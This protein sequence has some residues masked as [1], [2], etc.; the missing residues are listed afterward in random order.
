MTIKISVVVPIFNVE[1]YLNRC[2]ESILAQLYLNLE[3][4]LIDDGSTD[5]SLLICREYEKKDAR[6]KVYTQQNKGVS[7]ARNLGI[8]HATGEFI[9]F[10]DPD[11]WIEPRMYESMLNRIKMD[12]SDICLCDYAV[13]KNNKKIERTLNLEELKITGQENIFKSIILPLIG[14]NEN[15]INRIDGFVW[16]LLIKRNI[17]QASQVVF[18]KDIKIMEDLLFC[19]SLFQHCNVVSYD[20]NIFYNYLFNPKS[21][22][23]RYKPNYYEINKKVYYKMRQLVINNCNGDIECSLQNRYIEMMIGCIVNEIIYC[24]KS[25]FKSF[26]KLKQIIDDS[27]FQRILSQINLRQQKVHKRFLFYLIRQKSYIGVYIYYFIIFKVLN[28]S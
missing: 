19:I 23:N 1:L 10:V 8:Q 24:K 20:K 17:L 3:V 9:T 18:D 7:E 25:I 22:M 14:E 21:A 5:N 4:L 11:D 27:E 26:I 16:R 12:N 6:V 13:I 2:I 28:R 15:S